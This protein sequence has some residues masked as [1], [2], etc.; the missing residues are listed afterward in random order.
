MKTNLSF[1]VQY[2]ADSQST[3]AQ[4][5]E[6]MDS[7]G[8]SLKALLAVQDPAASVA[9]SDSHKG[10][11]NKLVEFTTTLGDAQIAEILKAFSARHG[12]VVSAFE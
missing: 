6:L 2:S 5:D 11:G 9:V 8:P 10:E 12:V 3:Q 1:D 4:R 7:L